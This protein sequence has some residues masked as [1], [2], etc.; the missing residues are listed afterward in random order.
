MTHFLISQHADELIS[1]T[2]IF[3]VSQT[4]L[5]LCFSYTGPGGSLRVYDVN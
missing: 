5:L 4:E 3:Y 2:D 1:A